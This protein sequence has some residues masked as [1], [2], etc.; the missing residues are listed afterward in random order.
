[1]TPEP[2]C[3]NRVLQFAVGRSLKP[4]GKMVIMTATP[5]QLLI[6]KTNSGRMS[7]VTI[8]AR[9]HRKPLIA[10]ELV[11]LALRFPTFPGSK[12]EPPPLIKQFLIDIKTNQRK[13][14]IFLPT[15]KLIEMIGNSLI[16]WAQ[17]E[18]IAGAIIHSKIENRERVKERF[19]DGMTDFLIASTVLERGIT[20]PDLDV[21][22]LLADNEMVF[23]SRTLVQIAGRVGRLGE[24]ARVIFTA[25]RITKAMRESYQWIVRMNEEGYRMGYLDKQ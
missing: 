25:E 7:L 11:K 22:V 18:G 17:T 8:P 13:A 10:P 5:D 20:I 2:S 6:A 4:E 19:R 14:L 16:Q 12:W 24:P 9:P 23:D 15:I 21:L 1:M 3:A